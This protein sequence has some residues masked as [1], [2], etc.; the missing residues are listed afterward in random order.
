VGKIADEILIDARN[1]R[2]ILPTRR[3]GT[4]WALRLARSN[5]D[6]TL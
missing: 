4:A 6:L 5:N 3:G 2:A 1:L